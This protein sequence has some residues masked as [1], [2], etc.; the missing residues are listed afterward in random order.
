MVGLARVVHSDGIGPGGGE[1]AA[2]TQVLED[3]DDAVLNFGLPGPVICFS[4]WIGIGLQ[5]TV[6][7]D[8]CS[9]GKVGDSGT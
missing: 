9:L 4:V 3:A 7:F 6:C 5:R 8:I 2:L 1:L